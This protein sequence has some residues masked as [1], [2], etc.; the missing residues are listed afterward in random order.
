MVFNTPTESFLIF[1]PVG[2]R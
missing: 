2:Y 1:G